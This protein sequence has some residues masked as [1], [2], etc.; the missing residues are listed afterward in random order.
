MKAN[1]LRLLALAVL[2][3]LGVRGAEERVWQYKLIEG[4]YLVDDC[5]ICGRPSIQIPLR[6]SFTLR[7]ISENPLESSYAVENVS[8]HA[9][10]ADQ[11]YDFTGSG[12]F[13]LGGEV[14]LHQEM[15]LTGDLVAPSGAKQTG[16]TNESAAVSRRLPMIG[17]TLRQTNGTLANT[18]SLGI[19]AAPIREIWFST[20][21]S[22]TTS[23]DPR[24]DSL[25]AIPPIQTISSGDLLSSAGRVVMEN[26]EFQENFP[27]PTYENM[28][29]DAVDLLP[30][31]EIGFSTDTV[32]VLS[33]GDVAMLRSG[34]ILRYWELMEPV[35]L[36]PL[37]DPGLDC[38]HFD[39]PNRFYF[40]IQNDISIF[41]D[42]KPPLILK[43]GDL[44]LTDLD[45]REGGVFKRNAELLSQFHPSEPEK[46]Y[47]LDA[48]FIWPSGEIWFSTE[49]GFTDNALGPISSGDL[50][51]DQGYIVYR[52]LELLS[53]FKPNEDLSNFGLDALVIISDALSEATGP[54][55]QAT[56]DAANHSL[57]LTWSGQ[58]RVFQVERAPTVTGPWVE[59]SP[60][61][62]KLRYEDFDVSGA[63]SA[64]FYRVRQW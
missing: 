56:F 40:S 7:L 4:S 8:F 19:F 41:Y 54:K 37:G 61:M 52:N 28:G 60:I 58:G 3:G 30:G 46:D 50:L 27:G 63:N 48:V 31:A 43:K 14:A 6:G 57:V 22:F 35:G 32:G 17:I 44:L 2:L 47:G 33:D 62:A 34:R 24:P 18:V 12:T 38:L 55:V 13:S 29:L 45:R 36:I 51:S 53:P 39:N 42:S 59:V 26:A 1:V 21:V 9:S 20:D 10:N 49:T 25:A 5:L 15:A 64:G 11:V 23:P 16:F